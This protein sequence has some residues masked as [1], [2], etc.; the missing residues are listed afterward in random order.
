MGL[1]EGTPQGPNIKALIEQVLSDRD[2][3]KK[4]REKIDG[5][6]EDVKLI[7]A[8]ICDSRGNCRLPTIEDLDKIMEKKAGVDGVQK[9]L[10]KRWP[11]M[12]DEEKA[13]L[14]LIPRDSHETM[15]KILSESP[16]SRKGLNKRVVERLSGNEWA[17][18]LAE[19]PRIAEMV[20]QGVCRSP[21][22]CREKYNRA[23]DKEKK[24]G[25]GEHWL[26]K[27]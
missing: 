3:Q 20:A 14:P 13:D 11:T 19:K 10:E 6:A 7:K 9:E 8:M 4:Q 22:E 27:E 15:L 21:E 16:K 5:M 23:L 25:K 26:T 17:E 12:S 2:G 18:L 24:E 1:E